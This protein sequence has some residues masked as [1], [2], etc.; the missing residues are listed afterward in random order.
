MYDIS[1]IGV[2]VKIAG[3]RLFPA[4]FK[5]GPHK[6]YDIELIIVETGICIIFVEEE[7]K[8]IELHENEGIII[9]PHTKHIFIIDESSSCRISQIQFE[10]TLKSKE[11]FLNDMLFAKHLNTGIRYDKIGRATELRSCIGRIKQNVTDKNLMLIYITEL[12]VLLSLGIEDYQDS[13]TRSFK[14]EKVKIII[15]YINNHLYDQIVIEDICK[16]FDVSSRYL[17]K[18]FLEATGYNINSYITVARINHAKELL[19]LSDLSITQISYQTGFSS[20]QYFNRVFKKETGYTP[21]EY[22]VQYY[23]SKEIF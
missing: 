19:S 22:R 4:G 12:L 3:V 2:S 1:K 14:Y 23:R 21:T 9:Y 20:S 10:I 18:K 15:E 8:N 11:L 5:Y 16:M 13:T 17:R 6:H 7:N